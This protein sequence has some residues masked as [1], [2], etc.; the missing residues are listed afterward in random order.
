MESQGRE[1]KQELSEATGGIVVHLSVAGKITVQGV[2]KEHNET[3][4]R[5]A[6]LGVWGSM[7]KRRARCRR[8]RIGCIKGLLHSGRR[9][10]GGK[11]CEFICRGRNGSCTGNSAGEKVALVNYQKNR[12]EKSEKV[13]RKKTVRCK[14]DT[15]QPKSRDNHSRP[16]TP[17]KKAN[18]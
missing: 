14:V 7:K 15:C 1:E 5:C 4:R 2:P 16:R 13:G 18:S 17:D 6:D 11:W 8:I 12:K 9:S 3:E 10:G